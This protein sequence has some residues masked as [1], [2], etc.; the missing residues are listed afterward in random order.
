MAPP[1]PRLH[2]NPPKDPNA[3]LL[4]PKDHHADD[5]DIEATSAAIVPSAPAPQNLFS[6]F[7]GG[8]VSTA[9]VFGNG[10][11]SQV[12]QGQNLDFPSPLTLGFAPST[13]S[14]PSQTSDEMEL[15]PH[16]A[17][18]PSEAFTPFED[19]NSFGA[20]FPWED[21]MA[22][23]N[24]MIDFTKWIEE[25]NMMHTGAIA[26]PEPAHNAFQ[27]QGP[28]QNTSNMFAN[29]GNPSSSGFSFG[30][31]E[32]ST[33]SQQNSFNFGQ[34]ATSAASQPQ[35]TQ[36][37][38]ID[39]SQVFP[40]AS[41]Q[42]QTDP[43]PAY[44][45]SRSSAAT[46][47]LETSDSDAMMIS[48]EKR[49]LG[50]SLFDRVEQ[51]PVDASSSP[52]TTSTAAPPAFSLGHNTSL[53]AGL[54]QNNPPVQT[55]PTSNASSGQND[56]FGRITAPPSFG[57]NASG[58]AAQSTD[59]L[60]A[61]SPAK[62]SRPIAE[63]EKHIEDR[64]T[65]NNPFGGIFL[66][67]EQSSITAPSPF[68][69]KPQANI[70]S[71]SD[72]QSSGALFGSSTINQ[73]NSTSPFTTLD[74]KS[75]SPST[76]NLFQ[77][78]NASQATG[79][80]AGSNLFEVQAQA[81]NKSAPLGHVKPS[82]G[83]SPSKDTRGPLRQSSTAQNNGGQ[84]AGV[85]SKSANPAADV[86]EHNKTSRRQRNQPLEPP[87]HWTAEEKEQYYIA[88]KLK[89]L[90]VGAE[91][92][93]KTLLAA[94]DMHGLK[95]LKQYYRETVRS[96]KAG[97]HDPFRPVSPSSNANE[98]EQNENDSASPSN[99][100]GSHGRANN[101]SPKRKMD[102]RTGHQ[103]GHRPNESSKR[104]RVTESDQ[105]S[106]PTLT[107]PEP[108]SNTSSMFKNILDKPAAA[109]NGESNT[110]LSLSFSKSSESNSSV[111]PQSS[112]NIFANSSMK[113]QAGGA[114]TEPAKPASSPFVFKATTSSSSNST[115][116]SNSGFKMQN[117]G[118]TSGP[119][120]FLAQFGQISAADSKKEMEKRKAEDMDSDEDEAEWERRDA[121]EQRA[122]KQ[123]TEQ[124]ASK[125]K[126]KYVAGKGF[127]FETN[128]SENGE[129]AAA[130]AASEA[131]PLTPPM[132][133][134]DKQH[135]SFAKQQV[136]A[137]KFGN[138]F[139][140]FGKQDSGN[141]GS[142]NG[143]ADDEGEGSDEEEQPSKK[144]TG[145]SLFD[146]ISA[147][148]SKANDD[149]HKDHP[150]N[151][152]SQGINMFGHLSGAAASVP[153]SNATNQAASPAKANPFGLLSS[154][155]TQNVFGTPPS[156]RAPNAPVSGEKG[157]NTWK[158]ESQIKF[159]FN[160]DAG[161]KKRDRED[162]N[163][164]EGQGSPKRADNK[165]API[166]NFT[167]PSP[168]KTPLGSLFGAAKPNATMETPSKSIFDQTAS[169]PASSAA[170]NF[171][172]GISPIKPAPALGSLFPP[173]N[174]ASL[175]ASRSNSPGATTGESATESNADG[176][177]EGAEK[178]EQ[179]NLTSGG[180]GEENEDVLYEVRAKASIWD[181]TKD[182]AETGK[183]GDWEIKGLGPFRIMKNRE[184]G[185]A[186]MLMRSDPAGRIIINSSISNQFK[187]DT[188][189]KQL[190]RIPMLSP[191]QKI[192]TWAVRV[193][194]GVDT[195]DIKQIL[196][197]NKNSN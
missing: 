46:K 121:E 166:F 181:D 142:K 151:A 192:E 51:P 120:N 141:E 102:D 144:S 1:G 182:N 90:D 67:K 9:N 113:M 110:G 45:F 53:Q 137:A 5:M 36:T 80:Q 87:P 19:S 176:D 117:F 196:N 76:S 145:G 187:I 28:S 38:P 64:P 47:G 114:T 69:P 178:H 139:A 97:H 159:G 6:G 96:I 164:E 72:M 118:S 23:T 101:A 4:H 148:S 123:K 98:V 77:L 42:P 63:P 81:T 10:N 147:P 52:V 193:G 60:R 71:T 162:D 150:L 100:Q 119:T 26:A 99:S 171:G 174:N 89:Q 170:S 108:S 88:Y 156:A 40:S 43:T 37:P 95:H 133:E 54:F 74:Q 48:P 66:S 124:E 177:D 20:S 91:A 169:T 105:V 184:T 78:S 197:E 154:S 172:F 68:A 35:T 16:E 180:P 7:G 31:Q 34:Q 185:K 13:P 25:A 79:Q 165:D 126:P 57:Q 3:H 56:L 127:V 94:R 22:W 62:E 32:S 15:D 168:S 157:D 179:L 61:S 122:K 107:T 12:P 188:P 18:T 111:L 128:E 59:S 17:L 104:A 83:E 44:A 33:N 130:E 155:A 55:V 30:Q 131:P 195:T 153:R 24:D 146:R 132:S 2:L 11:N 103:Q 116:S 175:G 136:S 152:S 41:T 106:Y 82:S 112:S 183:K 70:A 160:P 186:R 58:E 143:D 92:K 135:E 49:P 73:Q 27:S 140:K 138:P 115:A 93:R 191:N 167:S 29:L 84:H 85:P 14:A 161:N 8:S 163:T 194:K 149:A 190:L 109:I 189:T 50:R 86:K 39:W 158:L 173:S 134:L 65:P 75:A 129:P 125:L 21:N